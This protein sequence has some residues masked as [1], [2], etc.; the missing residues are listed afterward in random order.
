MRL[1]VSLG[2][3]LTKF[4]ESELEGEE[5]TNAKA[6]LVAAGTLGFAPAVALGFFAGL[7]TMKNHPEFIEKEEDEPEP[8]GETASEPDEPQQPTRMPP[9]PPFS[10]FT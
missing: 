8:E 7:W 5:R 3:I 2:K 6:M 9:P 4:I 10:L 1:K